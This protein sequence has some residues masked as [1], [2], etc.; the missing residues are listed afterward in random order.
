M[1]Y[2]CRDKFNK[3]GTIRSKSVGPSYYD[4]KNRKTN[5]KYIT[6]FPN[7]RDF[8]NPEYKAARLACYKRDN[9]QCV[10]CGSKDRIQ[11]H[12][13]LSWADYPGLRYNINNLVTL[14]FDCHK[15]IRG[16]EDY[17]IN[18]FHRLILNKTQEQEEK[19]EDDNKN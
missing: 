15:K 12:H 1:G 14:C 19:R 9:F 11:A 16:K 2:R 5:K 18:Y 6:R 4:R 7:T 10:E 17:Y 8:N 3:N 13:I